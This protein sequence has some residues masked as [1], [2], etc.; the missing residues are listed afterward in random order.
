METDTRR[1]NSRWEDNIKQEIGWGGMNW[2]DSG[3]ELLT[4]VLNSVMNLQIPLNVG[5][6]W[7]ASATVGLSGND[8]SPWSKYDAVSRQLP[9]KA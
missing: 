2:I 5:N 9:F 3:E 7:S 1:P 6:F 4:G 8:L